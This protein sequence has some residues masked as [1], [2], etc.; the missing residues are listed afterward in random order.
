MAS[1]VV[2]GF[3]RTSR[4]APLMPGISR[5]VRNILLQIS[6]PVCV[7]LA[8]SPSFRRMESGISESGRVFFV[9]NASSR[10]EKAASVT[11]I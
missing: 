11:M 4:L 10:E 7:G 3:S 1:T 2:E 9:C 8:E 6:I 5:I